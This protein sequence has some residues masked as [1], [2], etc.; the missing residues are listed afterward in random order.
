LNN[1]I[2][3]YNSKKYILNELGI[4]KYKTKKR[5]PL[6]TDICYIDK[7]IKSFINVY[8]YEIQ[9]SLLPEKEK[10]MYFEHLLQI[11]KVYPIKGVYHTST[12]VEVDDHSSIF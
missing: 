1:I 7:Q 12:H 3:R 8:P 6:Y 11:R 9:I 5:Y 10:N 2:K 4:K